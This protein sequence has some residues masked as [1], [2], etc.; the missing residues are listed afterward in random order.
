MKNKT[1]GL[2]VRSAREHKATSKGVLEGSSEILGMEIAR[3]EPKAHHRF[4]VQI[5]DTRVGRFVY[6]KFVSSKAEAQHEMERQRALGHRIKHV[7]VFHA[8]RG[9]VGRRQ[10][11]RAGRSVLPTKRMHRDLKV[12]ARKLDPQLAKLQEEIRQLRKQ[13]GIG[14]SEALPALVARCEQIIKRL[15]ARLA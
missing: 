9:S 14:V 5:Y 8:V 7:P 12:S 10:H 6:Y 4:E 13:L 2:T 1:Q 11:S 3:P 15:K